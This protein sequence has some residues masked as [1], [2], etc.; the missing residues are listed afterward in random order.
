MRCRKNEI[1]RPFNL[2]EYACRLAACSFSM[3]SCVLPARALPQLS[4]RLKNQNCK[5]G[6]FGALDRPTYARAVSDSSILVKSHRQTSW[7]SFCS[8]GSPRDRNT[9]VDWTKLAKVGPIV[10]AV[11]AAMQGI[12]TTRCPPASQETA[13]A[14]RC[15]VADSMQVLADAASGK[16]GYERTMT[17][18]EA[19]HYSENDDR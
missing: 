16:P 15:C 12:A 3:T 1:H 14:N 6:A 13:P 4:F 9:I 10:F 11:K 8:A 5:L 18:D 17:A 7:Q 19:P 2:Q